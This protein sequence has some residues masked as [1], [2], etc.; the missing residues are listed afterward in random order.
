MVRAKH[1]RYELACPDEQPRDGAGTNVQV[2]FRFVSNTSQTREGWYVDD[3]V[4]GP[5][6]PTGGVDWLTLTP[7]NGTLAAGA[8]TNVTLTFSAAGRTN[9]E[10]R[11]TTLSVSNNDPTATAA[12]L[13]LA[14][15]VGMRGTVL[16]CR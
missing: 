10:V 8:A 9:G 5:L 12:T 4:I 1:P 15:H 16:L 7:T 3:I 11:L 14:M 13:P 2:R 6:A